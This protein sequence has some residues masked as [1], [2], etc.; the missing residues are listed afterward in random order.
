ME[1]KPLDKMNRVEEKFEDAMM[2]IEEIKQK[3][4]DKNKEIERL[5]GT[6]Q[7]KKVS[8][9]KNSHLHILLETS[10]MNKLKA[11]AGDKNVSIAELV[12]Q[13]LR[14][15]EQLDRIERKIDLLSK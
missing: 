1:E 11:E 15:S 6:P 13:K 7:I 4:Q 10:L 2:L 5:K 8:E 12:R 14:G 9:K 3:L